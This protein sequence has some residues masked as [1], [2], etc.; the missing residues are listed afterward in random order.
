VNPSKGRFLHPD[1][2]RSIT[3]RE[4]ALLQTFPKDYWVSLRRGKFAAA[5]MIGNAF[6]PAFVQA[7]ATQILKHLRNY[8]A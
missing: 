1:Q 6:P 3:L 5:L 2:D 8:Y 7:H 4:A